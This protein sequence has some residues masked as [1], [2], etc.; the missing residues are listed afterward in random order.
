MAKDWT[1]TEAFAEYGV[2]CANSRWSWSGRSPDGT[3]VA[4][5][6]WSDRFVDFKSQPIV[7]RDE[8]WGDDVERVR[9]PGNKERINN[10]KFALENLSGIVRVVMAKAKDVKAH[11]R[12]IESC[13]PQPKLVMRITHFDELTGE[14]AAESVEATDAHRT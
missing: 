3:T 9:R 7:Y 1:K 10:I 11:P 6:F 13:W 12:E 5:T 8:G 4:L 14:W 2:E